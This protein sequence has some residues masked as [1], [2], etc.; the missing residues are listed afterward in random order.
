MQ[1]ALLV[2]GA[3]ALHADHSKPAANGAELRDW[4]HGHGGTV[5]Y[6]GPDEMAQSCAGLRLPKKVYSSPH[7]NVGWV[8]AGTWETLDGAALAHWQQT[9]YG[10]ET[11]LDITVMSKTLAEISTEPYDPAGKKAS[12]DRTLVLR[13]RACGE[14]GLWSSTPGPTMFDVYEPAGATRG[15]T[16]VVVDHR[17]KTLATGTAGKDLPERFT[18]R[19]GVKGEILAMANFR[20]VGGDVN[21]F[22]GMEHFEFEILGSGNSTL[23]DPASRWVLLAA[24]QLKGVRDADRQ[25]DGEVLVGPYHF[26]F[27]ALFAYL[28]LFVGVIFAMHTIHVWV[29]HPD[30]CCSF[31]LGPVRPSRKKALFNDGSGKHQVWYGLPYSNGQGQ[32]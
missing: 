4:R 32:P 5:V 24:T 29:Y 23:L 31:L 13:A 11:G 1:R 12:L 15:S 19:Q 14:P 2:A 16:L 7:P 3:I 9:S 30:N 26:P 6:G 8:R 25:A 28:A 20:K 27:A 22:A 10:E 21:L 17:N 18:W